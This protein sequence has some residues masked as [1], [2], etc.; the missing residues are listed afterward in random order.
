MLVT[1]FIHVAFGTRGSDTTGKYTAHEVDD[2][3]EVRQLFD[4]LGKKIQDVDPDF[5][6][7][8]LEDITA[9]S[10]ML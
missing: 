2:L 6:M 7:R 1:Q 10:Y 4:A 5:V 8:S 9:G 3:A